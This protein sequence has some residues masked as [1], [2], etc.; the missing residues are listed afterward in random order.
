MA[1]NAYH[2]GTIGSN[3]ISINQESW[4]EKIRSTEEVPKLID[5]QSVSGTKQ[6]KWI[7]QEL[8]NIILVLVTYGHYYTKITTH[9]SPSVFILYWRD[10]WSLFGEVRHVYGTDYE[11]NTERVDNFGLP[12]GT[13]LLHC[14]TVHWIISAGQVK[15]YL[16]FLQVGNLSGSDKKKVDQKCKY[17]DI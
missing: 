9:L 15:T 10:T 1:E 14:I 8:S 5:V 6:S 2:C 17:E 13:C 7:S 4:G 11:M 3:P 12:I 16:D